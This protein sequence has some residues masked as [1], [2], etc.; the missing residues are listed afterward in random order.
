MAIYTS[1]PLWYKGQSCTWY[2]SQ[3][4]PLL[5][6]FCGGGGGPWRVCM[7]PQFANTSRS[8]NRAE[9]APWWVAVARAATPAKQ[10]WILSGLYHID[11]SC[12]PVGPPVTPPFSLSSSVLALVLCGGWGAGYLCHIC[13][14]TAPRMGSHRWHVCFWLLSVGKALNMIIWPGPCYH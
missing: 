5:I 3:F 8:M 7:G 12:G 6:L 1:T 13:F 9:I 4:H 11:Q 10:S 2:L 14:Q